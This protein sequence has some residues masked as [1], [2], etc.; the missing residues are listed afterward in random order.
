MNDV[1]PELIA[2]IATRLYNELP[3]E[4]VPSIPVDASQVPAPPS[5]I[6]Q[7]TL[8]REV[9]SMATF[10]ALPTS[11]AIPTFVSLLSSHVCECWN[12]GTT[13]KYMFIVEWI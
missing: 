10:G 11:G 1:T 5:S 13:R 9:P 12:Q 3:G 8:P 2:Q 4:S 6:P 7:P